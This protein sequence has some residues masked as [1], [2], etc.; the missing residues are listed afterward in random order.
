MSW[1]PSFEVKFKMKIILNWSNN[2]TFLKPKSTFYT[3]V[4][5]LNRLVKMQFG[6][7]SE[8]KQ[9][10][11]F[12]FSLLPK[13]NSCCLYSPFLLWRSVC[14]LGPVVERQ[15]D[16]DPPQSD[17]HHRGDEQE[18]LLEESGASG[19]GSNHQGTFTQVSLQS[20]SKSSLSL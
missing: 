19:C 9:G 3:K 14:C 15:R 18:R 8:G 10:H 2:S 20:K 17:Q 1:I 4:R 6:T 11:F 5:H 16:E 13:P 12:V 7:I